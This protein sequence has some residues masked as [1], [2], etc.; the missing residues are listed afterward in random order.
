LGPYHGGNSAHYNV[1]ASGVAGSAGNGSGSGINMFANPSAVYAGFRRLILGVDNN[2]GGAGVLRGFGTFN[3][4]MAVT[5]DIRIREGMG[6]T[7]SFQFLN[8]LNHFQPG[9]PTLSIDSPG[10]FGVV[11]GQANTPRQMEFGL[12]LFF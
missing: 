4:D 12:R 3:L 2:G 9:N 11:T 7:L 6:A 5:K 8:V 1:V 10:S